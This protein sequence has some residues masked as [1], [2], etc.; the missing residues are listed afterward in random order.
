MIK[1][2]VFT[3]GKYATCMDEKWRRF[4]ILL[5]DIAYKELKESIKKIEK[6]Y[7]C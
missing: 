2:V 7:D 6:K 4:Q 3:D 1:V 5:P